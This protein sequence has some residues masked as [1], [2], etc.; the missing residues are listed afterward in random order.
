MYQL[1]IG[2][3]NYSSWSLRPWI[4]MK[5]FNIEF[6]EKNAPL[7]GEQAYREYVENGLLPC[8]YDDGFNVWDSL[9]IAEYLAEKHPEMW[10]K[11]PKA[12]ARARCIAAEMHSGFAN[13]RCVMPMNIKLRAQGGDLV[14]SV[15]RD[16][17]RICSIWREARQLA[18]IGPYLFG[19][20]SV[21]DAMYAPVVWR[22]HCYNVAL[23]DDVAIYRDV[24]LKHPA[25]KEWEQGALAEKL[26]LPQEDMLLEA[27]GG[28]R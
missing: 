20:F 24:M 27:F 2:S 11:N 28:R 12:R 26:V 13:L 15:K 4:L 7:D 1:H 16:I 6:L 19:A 23:P 22:L 21:A 25:M 8:L 9:A 10:P 14:L 17:E 5:H 18:E 3:K